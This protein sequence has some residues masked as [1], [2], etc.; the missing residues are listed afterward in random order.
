M[1]VKL[2]DRSLSQVLLGGGN[3]GAARQIGDDLLTQ[4]ASVEDARVGIGEAPLQVRDNAG[5]SSLLAEIVR[6]LQVQVLVG[7]T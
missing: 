2:T 4:P 1:P 3:V 6:V 7:S 5:I